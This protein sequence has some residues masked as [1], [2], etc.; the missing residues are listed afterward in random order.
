M[1]DGPTGRGGSSAEGAAPLGRL[2]VLLQELA[3]APSEDLHR[4]WQTRL[5][6]GDVVGRFEIVR[7]IGRGGFAV[8]YEA[9]D[10]QLGRSV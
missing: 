4:A 7:E 5:R 6:P 9:L 2:S 3:R 8:V 1:P 10:Q